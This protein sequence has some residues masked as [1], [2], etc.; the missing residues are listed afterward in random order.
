MSRHKNKQYRLKIDPSEYDPDKLEQFFSTEAEGV[1]G[2]FRH[3]R[4]GQH[5][6]PL[7]P[8]EFVG[9]GIPYE[10]SCVEDGEPLHCLVH[11]IATELNSSKFELRSILEDDGSIE[12]QFAEEGMGRHFSFKL[13]G[14]DHRQASAAQSYFQDGV[15]SWFAQ[16]AFGYLRAIYVWKS[17]DR[18][19]MSETFDRLIDETTT[20]YKS[21]L[22]WDRYKTVEKRKTDVGDL[23]VVVPIQSGRRPREETSEE[24][25]E[26]VFEAMDEIEERGG[27]IT[28]IEVGT[29]LYSG[30][31]A[32]SHLQARLRKAGLRWRDLKAEHKMRKN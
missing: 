31:D 2:A 16:A 3:G 30:E 20:F 9:E 27:D 29:S 4:W 22:K 6:E 17:G 1:N 12:L 24:L 19:R 10:C 5:V 26:W 32:R 8:N 21:I 14:L 11:G 15:G 25:R 28:Q 18:R 23:E 13:D 7:G